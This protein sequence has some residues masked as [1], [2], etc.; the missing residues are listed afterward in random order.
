MKHLKLFENF[1]EPKF[2]ITELDSLQFCKL[3]DFLEA[4]ISM[5]DHNDFQYYE[6]MTGVPVGELMDM[7]VG[8]GFKTQKR[9]GTE[10]MKMVYEKFRK[11]DWKDIKAE[12]DSMDESESLD[13]ENKD[14]PKP[15]TIAAVIAI[16]TL[17]QDLE[18]GHLSKPK[19]EKF[20]K[21]FYT[22]ADLQVMLNDAPLHP[23]HPQNPDRHDPN[24]KR[25]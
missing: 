3:I 21:D 8:Y 19:Q 7:Y 6:E 25:K 24:R 15:A 10:G 1:H 17:C 23:D 16:P 2:N 5:Y 11:M 13:E 4:D 20:L 12:A 14:T 9:E 22:D 18:I